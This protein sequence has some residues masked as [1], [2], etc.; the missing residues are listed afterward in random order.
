M[1]Q[2][3][4]F[5]PDTEVDEPDSWIDQFYIGAVTHPSLTDIQRP[6]IQVE[7]SIYSGLSLD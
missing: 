2:L 5:R 7:L 6:L 3:S 1:R 4:T